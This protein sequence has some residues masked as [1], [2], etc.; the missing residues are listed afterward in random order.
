[1]IPLD[2]PFGSAMVVPGVSLREPDHADVMRGEETQFLGALP[3]PDWTG[4]IVHP[5]TH[6]KW[7]KF[8]AGR[9]V[10][11]R[12]FM[13]G[14]LFELLKTRSVLRLLMADGPDNEAAADLGVQ[15]A[16]ADP[17]ITS[18]L[19]TAR[20]EVLLGGLS[21]AAVASY[22]SGLL[23]GAEVAS[24]V[25]DTEAGTPLLLVG[26]RHLTALYSRA[27]AQ[28][29]LAPTEVVDGELAVTRGLW[30]LHEERSGR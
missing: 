3:A 26:D 4:V 8:D 24:G 12:T 23:I 27:L 22:L 16:I 7:A 15:R 20:A 6:A 21:E 30:R 11:F 1:M 28:A 25:R 9:L 19:F 29:D 18:L 17:A 14:E 2:T 5:G 10:S 13:T